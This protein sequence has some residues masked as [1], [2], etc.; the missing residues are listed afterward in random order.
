MDG[1]EQA[2]KDLSELETKRQAVEGLRVQIQ[3]LDADMVAASELGYI[4][5]GEKEPS[6]KMKAL[7][8]EKRVLCEKEKAVRAHLRH[9]DHVAAALDEQEWLALKLFFCRGLKPG[10]AVRRLEDRLHISRS[11]VYRLREV[12]LW[13]F[14]CRMGYIDTTPKKGKKR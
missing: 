2:K 14:A 3:Q 1:I 10:Q 9:V 4:V 6:A 12:A 13:H 8:D 5:A 7:M 11:E